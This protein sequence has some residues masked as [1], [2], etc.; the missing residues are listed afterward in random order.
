MSHRKNPIPTPVR[1]RFLEKS[2]SRS[3]I[4]W[5]QRAGLGRVIT[6]HSGR[7]GGVR[8]PFQFQFVGSLVANTSCSAFSSS[9]KRAISILRWS[10]IDCSKA[11]LRACK[12]STS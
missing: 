10:A 6:G 7:M 9:S 11:A 2:G 8:S 1:G 12:R 3:K 4:I 5:S